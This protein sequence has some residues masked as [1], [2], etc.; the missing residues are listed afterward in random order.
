MG[1]HPDCLIWDGVRTSVWG[2]PIT[3]GPT[4]WG[5]STVTRVSRPRSK[6]A[7]RD[8]L[9]H[10]AGANI[11]RTEACMGCRRDHIP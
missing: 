3:T 9:G 8:A 11:L 1:A 2:G 7:G 6:R 4:Q 10:P 5:W